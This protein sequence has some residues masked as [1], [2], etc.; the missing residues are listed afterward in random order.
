MIEKHRACLRALTDD[1]LDTVAEAMRITSVFV[2]DALETKDMVQADVV[3]ALLSARN[4][5]RVTAALQELTRLHVVKPVHP[6][7]K[8]LPPVVPRQEP[9]VTDMKRNLR[10]PRLGKDALRVRLGMTRAEIIRSGVGMADLADAVT[11]G[12][13]KWGQPKYSTPQQPP[14]NPPVHQLTRDE[15]RDIRLWFGWGAVLGYSTCP[16][17]YLRSAIRNKPVFL[18]IPRAKRR[19]M[20]L[21]VI[22]EHAR[23]SNRPNEEEN[24]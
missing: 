3:M 4:S 7:P 6:W 9:V 18:A 16:K 12:W 5:P 10:L 20:L 13:I 23:R 22:K 1:A 17:E 21:F 14:N 11:E 15:V 2:I 8:P 24:Q 19:A